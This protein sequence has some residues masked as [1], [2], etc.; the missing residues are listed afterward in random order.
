MDNGCFSLSVMHVDW[1]CVPHLSLCV[2]MNLSNSRQFITPNHTLT[3]HL[4]HHN[5]KHAHTHTQQLLHNDR[6]QHAHNHKTTYHRHHTQIATST[7]TTTTTT[8]AVHPRTT[9][10][11]RPARR[12]NRERR[13]K[14]M[15]AARP[16]EK[17]WSE[18]G[19][20][21]GRMA[22]KWGR[23]IGQSTANG[24]GATTNDCTRRCDVTSRIQRDG[25]KQRQRG[26]ERWREAERRRQQTDMD[27][28]WTD[29]AE[30]VRSP[31]S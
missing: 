4:P 17:R 15:T 21:V 11:G 24:R 10:A 19:G 26:R 25:G 12:V 14:T 31:C 7:T 13:E 30:M 2:S 5:T 29:A 27:G 28:E 1:M 16:G 3:L 8:Q 22:M 23:L 18:G 6:K 9:S 20:R